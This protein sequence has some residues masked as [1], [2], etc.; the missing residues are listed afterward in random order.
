MHAENTM[1]PRATANR[2]NY[3]AHF[4]IESAVVVT[5]VRCKAVVVSKKGNV[6]MLYGEYNFKKGLVCQK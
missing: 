2:E 6:Q 1:S 3:R 4:K 5:T